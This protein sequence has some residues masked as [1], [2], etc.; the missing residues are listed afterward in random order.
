MIPI[1][2]PNRPFSTELTMGLML[3][4]GIFEAALGKQRLNAQFR[5]SGNAVVNNCSLYVESVSNPSIIITPATYTLSAIGGGAVTVRAW[6]IDVSMAPVGE[7]YVSFI[8]GH[9][10]GNKRIIKKI[11]VTRVDFNPATQSFSAATPEGILTARFKQLVVPA[12]VNCCC[13][14]GKNSD[15]TGKGPYGT[16]KGPNEAGKYNPFVMRD[17]AELFARV[18]KESGFCPPGYLPLEIET[19]VTPTPAFPGQ[20]GDLPFNDPW[21]KIILC[22]I[23]LLLLIAAAINDAVNGDGGIVVTGGNGGDPG[24]P[25]SNCCGVGAE[26]G[27]SN[28]V[29]AGLVA[30]AAVVATIAA[31]SDVRDP[32]RRGQD[33]TPPGAGEYTI[34]EKI[35]AQFVYPEPIAPGRPFKAG[36]NWKYTRITTD[37]ANHQRTYHY[38]AEDMNENM[39]VLSRYVINAPDVVRVYRKEPFIVRAEFFDANERQLSGGGLFVKCFLIGAG[40]RTVSFLLLDD[41]IIPDKTA[42][43]GV[44]TGIHYFSREDAGLWK[45]YVIAQDINTAQPGMEPE[46]AAQ[47]IGGML[48]THQLTI[49]FEGGTCPFV[50]DGDVHVIA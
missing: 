14:H 7:H 21:W 2:I 10:S 5:N 46:E 49:T 9:A 29:T 32:Y 1:D 12:D 15:G 23:A 8:A 44:Y 11:F 3:P 28:G 45:I 27:S 20:Y 25:N 47:I 34:Q 16:G 13:N 30:A 40:G 6:D 39:H 31:A 43:D 18:S 17:L 36:L 33:N 37:A 22:I 24:N 48:L 38:S 26:G 50:A 41:G 35:D 42:N 19:S 4:D